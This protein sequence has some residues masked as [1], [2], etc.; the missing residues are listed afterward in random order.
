MPR[1]LRAAARRGVVLLALAATGCTTAISGSGSPEAGGATG[2]GT[3]RMPAGAPTLPF[4]DCTTVIKA[5]LVG[6]PGDDRDLS[7]GCGKMAVPASY[8]DPT[9]PT[10]DIVVVRA[11]LNSQRN[12][13]GSLVVN[14]GGPGGSGVEAG[15][16]LSLQLPL[17]VLRRFDIVGFDPRGV[18]ASTPLNCV[19]AS[20]KEQAM[21]SSA[22]ATTAAAFQDFQ[23]DAAKVATGCYTRYHDALDEFSTESTARDMELLRRALGDPKLTYLGYSYGTLL[24]AV[25]AT[26]FPERVRALVLDGAVD[27]TASDV[28]ATEAQAAGFEDAFDQYATDCV[29]GHCPLA[30]DPRAF[31]TRLMARAKAAPIPSSI[32]IDHRKATDGTV[33]LAIAAAL[34]QREDWPQLTTALQQASQGN[35]RGL[36]ALTDQYEQRRP[37]GSFSNLMDANLVINCTDQEHAPSTAQVKSA[38]TSWRE[39][40]P[41]FGASAALSLLACQ[42]W[43]A[44]RDPPPA[45]H[46]PTTP[47][48]L[49]IGNRHDPATPYANAQH[50]TRLLGNAVLLTWDGTGHTAYPQTTCVITTV[51]TYLISATPPKPG[52]VCPAK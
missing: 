1:R 4:R 44:P 31:V 36:F 20:E 39:K 19:P 16:G 52:K 35:S 49:V 3:P 25:Y 11:H 32:T 33:L 37:N 22:D 10:I 48:I 9:G 38:L 17:N 14:P 2:T 42:Q 26:L 51:D 45:V 43:R 8:S 41:L 30:P 28:A 21:T 24:G 40:Y 5:A 18:G 6:A 34:Y 27:P 29:L 23:R 12:R 47:P 50:L 13:I 15:L 46:A 7:F